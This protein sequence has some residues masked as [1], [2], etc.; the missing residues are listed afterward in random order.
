MTTALQLELMAN[1]NHLHTTNR[2]ICRVYKDNTLLT[3]YRQ[4]IERQRQLRNMLFVIRKGF[5][6]SRGTFARLACLRW[7]FVSFLALNVITRLQASN[8]YAIEIGKHI[9][10]VTTTQFANFYIFKI[11]YYFV[12]NV[13]STLFCVLRNI[14]V[15]III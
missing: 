3:Y 7:N 10:T 8:I 12:Y 6:R 15:N 14:N 4:V 11:F 2:Q 1:I 13:I 9:P 5:G